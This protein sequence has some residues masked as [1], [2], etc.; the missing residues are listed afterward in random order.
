MLLLHGI[1]CQHGDGFGLRLSGAV[2]LFCICGPSAAGKTTFAAHLAEQLRARGR[3]P[4]LIACD[5]YYRSG[6]SPVSRYGF[7]TVDAIDA[8]QLRLQVSAVRYRQ[9]DSLRS[10]DMRAR[11]VGSR[12]L[13]Q[14]YDLILVEG[15][16]G[17]QLLLEAVPI[18]LVVYIEAPVVQRLIRR[19]W[20]DVRD[21]HRP[22]LYVIRQMLREML[23]GERRFIY[24]L[25]R[26]ADVIIQGMNKGLENVLE[27]ID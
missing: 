17:P 24:P 11:K 6:W 9:L 4:L 3:H 26:R 19:L 2:P 20:R 15:S 22:A 27:R 13:N 5:D 18:S 21:R 25:K 10:Y 16:Y 8:D 7:D 23:P 1:R 12:P 14:P